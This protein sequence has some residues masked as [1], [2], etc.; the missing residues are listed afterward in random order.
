MILTGFEPFAG[1]RINRSWAAVQ[2]VRKRADLRS[3]QLPVDFSALRRV[4]P[5]LVADRPQV[6]LLVGETDETHVCVEVVA[7]NILH[8]DHPDNKGQRPRHARVRDGRPLAYEATWTP[9]EVVHAVRATGVH[10]EIS[11]HAGTYACNAALY[12]AL[13]ASA[14]L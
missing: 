14:A 3:V 4:V 13:D 8:A 7:T 6:L 10:A 5:E 9:S 12:L 1:R 2:H 11:H